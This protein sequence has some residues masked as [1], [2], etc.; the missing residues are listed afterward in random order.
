[1]IGGRFTVHIIINKRGDGWR[2]EI[3]YLCLWLL[4]QLPNTIFIFPEL[5]LLIFAHWPNA[6]F[7]F[8]ELDLLIFA[9]F[10]SCLLI[11]AHF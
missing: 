6:I 1:M 10:C 3:A 11:F 5:D 2:L 4:I 8:P 7:I 9:H